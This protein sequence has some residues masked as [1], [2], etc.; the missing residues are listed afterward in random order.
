MSDR[1]ES[2]DRPEA[3]QARHE[4]TLL[5]H[6]LKAVLAVALVVY[7]I[8]AALF[9]GLRYV[10]LP[11]IDDFRPRIETLVSDQLHAQLRIGKLAPHWSG[12]QPG[13]DVT[14]LTIRGRDGNLALDVPHATAT[15]SWKSLA[16]FAPRLSSLVVDRPDVLAARA[17]DGTLTVAGVQVPTTHQGNDTFSTW[18]LEQRAIVLNGGTL[19]WRDARR[20]APELEL[21]HIRV[22]ILNDG[23]DH[24]LA[25]QAPADGTVFNGPLDFRARFRH[26]P[27]RAIGKPLN[28]SGQAYVSTGP[29]D[30]PTLARYIDFPIKTYAGRIDNEIWVNFSGG[31]IRSATGDLEGYDVALRV[32][33]TQPRLDVPSARF[34][35]ALELDPQ[36]DYTLKLANLHAELGQP[37]LPDG[38]PVLRTLALTTLTSRYRA[39]NLEHGQLISVTG[40]RVDLGV[41]AEFSRALPVPQRFRNEL[42]RFNPHGHVA[43]YLIEVERA[44]PETEQ[45]ASEQRVSGA[46]PIVRYRFKAQLQGISLAAQ[47]PPPGLSAKGHPRAGVPGFENLWGSVDADETHGTVTLDT[48]NAALTIPGAFDDPRLT[49]DRLR[50]RGNW[51]ITPAAPGEQHKRL[52]VTVSELS[53]ANADTAGSLVANYTNPGHG[54]GSLDL[55]ADIEQAAV[56]RIVRYLPTSISENLRKYLDH[57]LQAGTARGATIEV[58]GNLDQFPYS[59]EPKAGVFHIVAPFKG[60]KFDPSP[61]PPKTL[62]NGTPNVWPALDGIDGVFELKENVLRFA[63]DRA[64][65]KRVALTRVS[66]RIDDLGTK[67]SS[68]VIDGDARGPLADLLDYVNHSAVAGM[69][70]HIGEQVRAEGPA[71]LALK[72]IV[73]R[74]PKPHVAVEGTVG[75]LGNEL[76][77]DNVPP[78]SRLTGKV[79]FSGRTLKLERVAGRFLGGEVRADGGLKADG[80]YAFAASGRVAVDAA[81]GLDLRGPAA[82]LLAHLNGSAPYTVSVRGTKGR[83][84][85]VSANSDLTGLALDFPAPFDKALGTPMPLKLTLKPLAAGD[86]AGEGDAGLQRADLTLGPLAAAYLL[87]HD[88]NRPPEVVRGAIGVNRPAD[89]PSEGVSAAADVDEFDA[90]AWRALAGELRTAREAPQPGTSPGTAAQFLPS[91]FALHF[92]TL[93]LLKR[94]WENVV[95]GASHVG[96][97]WQANIGSNEVSGYMSWQP[98]AGRNNAGVL[99]ARFAKVVIPKAA[100]NDLVG[101]VMSS[102]SQNMPAIDLV[103]NDLVVREHSV[104]RLEVDA[105]NVDEAGMPVWQLDK[106]EIDNPS[107]KLTATANWRTARR[108]TATADDDAPRRTAIDFKLDI[109]DAGALLDRLGLPRTVKAGAGSLAG[110][111]RWRGGPTAIDYPTLSGN[112]SLDLRHGQILK[113]DPGVAKLLGVLSLQSLSRFLTLNFKDVIGEGLPFERV[114]GTGRITNGI[115]STNDF[116]M[117]TAPARA[118]LKGTVDLARET[119]ELHVNVVPTIN[120][121]SAVIAATIVNPLFGLGALVANVALSQSISHAFAQEYAIT[122][123]W[124]HPHIE[125]VR[126]DQ[127]KMAVPAEATGP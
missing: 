118:D 26:A 116:M 88:A 57:G 105:R 9:I 6:A 8:A 86:A 70:G 120:A 41:L 84:P 15:V 61:Y 81:R 36:R 55:K 43:N 27:L 38:T 95:V 96:T 123:S 67:A 49:F 21:T 68:L 125:R 127:G 97:K 114:T 99:Q 106:L 119:Q 31:H 37:P 63:I 22:A 39:P 65:Y 104:G 110:K 30:L 102:S 87:R 89:L 28:W 103:V 72:L 14:G 20:D 77:L 115:G 66:G 98:G 101:R 56:A 82:A 23:L 44:K 62:A 59:L 91:R 122:G 24:R 48:V 10:L 111:V 12:F 69:T 29:V 92:N 13:I 7:F 83:L 47:E 79:G 76:A 45:A 18:L 33:P 2:V 32:R 73:P 94:Q 5:R 34:S 113:V 53:V 71:T 40:D 108:P 17:A 90:D 75:L 35:W 124:A 117:V 16:R 60:A 4:P 1:K 42:V 109:A 112:L 54:R 19:R 80:S 74:T 107:A 11:R 121:G 64:R 100:E 85:D 51:T 52:A 25:L 50:G 78:L 126:G 93:K 46:A 58:H 3:A